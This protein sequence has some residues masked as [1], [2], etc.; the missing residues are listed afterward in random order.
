MLKQMDY[1]TIS[2]ERKSG[3]LPAEN[4]AILGMKKFL[5]KKDVQPCAHVATHKMYGLPQSLRKPTTW[6]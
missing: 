3:G 1:G 4:A 2:Q 5:S 6:Q